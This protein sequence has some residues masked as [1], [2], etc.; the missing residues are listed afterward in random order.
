[1]EFIKKFA[2]EISVFGIV[3]VIFICLYTYR[4]MTF[5]DYKTIDQED[6]TEMIADKDNFVLVIGDSTDNSVLAFQSIMT[7]FTTNYRSIPLYYIDSSVDEEFNA[8]V[9]ET[10][11][12]NITYPSTLVIKNGEVVATKEGTLQY[13]YL[14]DFIKENYGE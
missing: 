7:E 1:M 9:D 6:L 13:Y 2:K 8:Y 5:K 10:L 4:Q 3:I 14:V 11:K 12:T